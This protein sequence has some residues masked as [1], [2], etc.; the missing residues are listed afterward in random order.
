MNCSADR[1][2]TNKILGGKGLKK[3]STLVHKIK[4]FK[5]SKMRHKISYIH[6][7]KED[8]LTCLSPLYG[9]RD[10]TVLPC[11]MI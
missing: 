11:T 6:K 4:N 10:A 3:A 5:T 2:I 7:N 8:S 1:R 9:P